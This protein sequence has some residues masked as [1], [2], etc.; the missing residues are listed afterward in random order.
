MGQWSCAPHRW[1][2]E[3]LRGGLRSVLLY[4][5]SALHLLRCQMVAIELRMCT[6]SFSMLSHVNNEN[7]HMTYFVGHCPLLYVAARDVWQ[8]GFNSRSTSLPRPPLDEGVRKS[9]FENCMGID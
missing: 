8:K 3:A 6:S 2:G 1:F 9:F 4:P 5:G 7:A